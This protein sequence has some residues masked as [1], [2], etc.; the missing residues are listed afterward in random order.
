MLHP[1]YADKPRSSSLY[2]SEG[3]QSLNPLFVVEKNFIHILIK[4]MS[5]GNNES[6][7]D[8]CCN[9]YIRIY[10]GEKI[11]IHCSGGHGRT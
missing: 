8:L 5:V 11:Y 1:A 3:F 7:I 9:L 10:K 6:I 4:N 2:G